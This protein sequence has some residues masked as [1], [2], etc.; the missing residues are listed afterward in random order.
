MKSCSNGFR[1]YAN[2]ENE[3]VLYPMRCNDRIA[4]LICAREYSERKKE[5]L[6][7]L[8]RSLIS[9]K[10]KAT[11]LFG[12]LT[13]PK[14]FSKTLEDEGSKRKNFMNAARETLAAFYPKAGIYLVYQNWAKRSCTDPHWHIHFMI[15]P[16]MPDGEDIEPDIDQG[17]LLKVWQKKLVRN[18]VLTLGQ[19]KKVKIVNL[20]RLLPSNGDFVENLVKRLDYMI[21]QPIEDIQNMNLTKQDYAGFISL[22]RRIPKGFR[23]FRLLGWLSNRKITKSLERM[24]IDRLSKVKKSIS[25]RRHS[26]GRIE[27]TETGQLFYNLKS[28]KENHYWRVARNSERIPIDGVK[29]LLATRY[30][31][32]GDIFVHS[33]KTKSFI[34][35]ALNERRAR[36]GMIGGKRRT[37]FPAPN[38]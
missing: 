2:E 35:N 12:E 21:R 17:E 19:S 27:K 6:G 3:I 16:W 37:S 25:L 38:S 23:R 22:I 7:S 10:G 4:C 20:N 33:R 31:Q 11:V 24:G 9:A 13:I 34:D 5:K 26:T 28:I 8:L 14:A 1:A 29:C 30:S 18:K 32:K 15:L 36:T